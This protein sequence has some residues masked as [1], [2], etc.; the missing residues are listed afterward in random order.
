MAKPLSEKLFEDYCKSKSIVC[1]RIPET[2][3]KTPDYELSIGDQRIIVEV[4]E[5]TPNK[6]E[7]KSN[8]LLLKRG[9]G[10]A[11]SNTPGGRV[12]KKINSSSQ[13]IKTETKGIHP[14]ILVLFDSG[15][16]YSHLDPYDIRV[17]MYGLEQVYFALP[18]VGSEAPYVTG[19]GYGPK[20]KM[21]PEHN[22]SISAIGALFRPRSGEV[23]LHVYHNKFALVPLDVKLLRKYEIP[24]FELEREMSGTTAMWREVLL[25]DEP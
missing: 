20:R 6:E 17:G 14:S 21:T 11:L 25:N 13:Q 10:N 2:D 22:T 16:K 18:P 5:I 4:K 7:K 24:Q 15:Q 3:S 19:S 12:R 1:K 23:L 8:Q 9:Y